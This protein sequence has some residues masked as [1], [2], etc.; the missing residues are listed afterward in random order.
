MNDPIT[1]CNALFSAQHC[2]GKTNFDNIEINEG[3]DI[4]VSCIMETMDKYFPLESSKPQKTTKNPPW[5]NRHIK[6]R[7]R[8]RQLLYKKSL[9]DPVRNIEHI[10]QIVQN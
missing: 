6:N 9:E 3:I 4:L 1:A 10:E 5:L 7:I 8:H 2:L